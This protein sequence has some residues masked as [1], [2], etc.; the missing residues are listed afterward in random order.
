MDLKDTNTTLRGMVL[1]LI[2]VGWVKTT[3]GRILLGANGQTH[4][5]HWLNLNQ[6]GKT[7]DFGIKPL[8]RIADLID[9]EVHVVFINRSKHQ[10]EIEIMNNL[11]IEFA[12]ELENSCTNALSNNI[13]KTSSIKNSRSPVDNILDELLS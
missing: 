4:M 1:K 9:Y 12:N 5:N 10:S 7:T 11:N 13:P 2:N 3:I 8:S 6:D